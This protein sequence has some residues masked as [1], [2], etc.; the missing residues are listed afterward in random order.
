MVFFKSGAEVGSL[1]KRDGH[2]EGRG[3]KHD[4]LGV[5]E[6]RLRLISLHTLAGHEKSQAMS[7]SRRSI[8]YI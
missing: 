8:R 2:G 1:F 4:L 5:K 3:V 7:D 6:T